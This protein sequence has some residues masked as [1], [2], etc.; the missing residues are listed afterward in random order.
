MSDNERLEEAKKIMEA[1]QRQ[2]QMAANGGLPSRAQTTTES[3]GIDNQGGGF[4]VHGDGNNIGM[5]F[6]NQG[7]SNAGLHPPT[8][9]AAQPQISQSPVYTPPSNGTPS[10][11]P[12]NAVMGRPD[13]CPQCKLMHPP[14]RPGEKCPNAGVDSSIKITGIDD[15][16]I[17]K[18]LVDLKN[19]ILS[20]LTSKG[21]KDGKKFLQY[22]VIEL[23]KALEQYNE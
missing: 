21:I 22:S 18:H 23:T 2:T 20:Q 12:D 5:G 14:L 13:I 17:N 15:V 1:F 9:P 11:P 19:I 7:E 16:I 8:R 3:N 10:M 6:D 4:G